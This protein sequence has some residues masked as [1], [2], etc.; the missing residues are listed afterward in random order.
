MNELSQKDP[1]RIVFLDE[2]GVKTNMTRLRG[3]S[4][5][6]SRLVCHAPHGHWNSTTLISTIRLNGQTAAMELPGALNGVAFLIYTE[7][8]L[9]P[10]LLPGDI[11]IMDNLSVH[12]H[13]GAIAL[14]EKNGIKVEFLPP[15]SPDF[16][17]IEKMWSKLKALLRGMEARTQEALSQAISLSL[18]AVT[19]QDAKGWFDSCY[20]ATSQD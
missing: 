2:T 6:G 11:L 8:I 16:N 14:L 5:G 10:S 17:P 20:I 4:K 18:N 12:Y 9:L 13:A 7:N 19:P 15:Y 3:R 1:S